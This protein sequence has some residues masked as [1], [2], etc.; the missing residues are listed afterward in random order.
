MTFE[1]QG[2]L[3]SVTMTGDTLTGKTMVVI[4]IQPK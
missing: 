1:K 2:R 4:A 3:A